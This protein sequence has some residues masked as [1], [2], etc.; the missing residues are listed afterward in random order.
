ME[1]VMALEWSKIIGRYS[2]IVTRGKVDRSH[3]AW[4]W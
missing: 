2:I 3:D 4:L 1:V